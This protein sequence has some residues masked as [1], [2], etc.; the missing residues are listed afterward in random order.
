MKT[1]CF[2]FFSYL[3]DIGVGQSM[4]QVCTKSSQCLNG[5]VCEKTNRGEVAYKLCNCK[6]A[7][8][9]DGFRYYGLFCQNKIENSSDPDFNVDDDQQYGDDDTV[10]NDGTDDGMITTDKCEKLCFNGGRCANG[11]CECADGYTG[12]FCQHK[13]DFKVDDDQQYGDDDAVDDNDGNNEEIYSGDDD[14]MILT[15]KCDGKLCYNGGHCVNDKCECVDGY[16]GRFCQKSG[17]SALSWQCSNGKKCLN[18]GLCVNN[19]CLCTNGFTGT[20]C[21]IRPSSYSGGF[22]NDGGGDDDGE[23]DSVDEEEREKTVDCGNS[24]FCFNGGICAGQK[25]CSCQNSFTGDHCEEASPGYNDVTHCPDGS[26]CFNGG[27]CAGQNRCTCAEGFVGEY[28]DLDGFNDSDNDITHCPDGGFCFNGGICDGQ[29]RCSCQN[30]FTGDHCEEPPKR[31]G[32]NVSA[33]ATVFF[34]L[35]L[36]F[37][38]ASIIVIVVTY[39]KERK[40]N[41]SNNEG[42]GLMRELLKTDGFDVASL[43]SVTVP[44]IVVTPINTSEEE[45]FSTVANLI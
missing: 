19:K 12:R 37:L 40:R 36:T 31:R 20:N 5:G 39:T 3:V 38:G 11:N 26:S 16:N 7:I 23:D 29:K 13:G 1:L 18:S 24:Y 6:N 33:G 10:D 41:N 28:C 14:A 17:I 27:I 42:E 44:S 22:G 32:S 34:C 35:S 4:S 9:R 15:T 45:E 30:G 2:L 25:R 43:P 21:E 8:D